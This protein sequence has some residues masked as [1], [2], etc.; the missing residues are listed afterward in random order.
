MH[1]SLGITACLF[2]AF[3]WAIA[4]VF[5]S[6]VPMRAA[7]IAAFKNTFAT[8][9]MFLLLVG[10][11]WPLGRPVFQAGS[12]AW[13]YLGWSGVIGLVLGDVAY[14]R[15]LQILGPRQGLTLTLLTPPLTALLGRYWLSERLTLTTWCAIGVTLAG[16]AVVMRER[17]PSR[18]EQ[19]GTAPASVAWGLLCALV[20]VSAQ[21]VGSIL[22]KIGTAGVGSVE[23]TFIRLLVA[24]LFTLLGA[25]LLRRWPSVRDVLRSRRASVE[26]TLAAF[27]GTFLG[28]WLMLI[29]FKYCEAGV[30]STLL[31]TSPLFIIPIAWYFLG[32]R[33][34]WTAIAGAT[35]AFV[36]AGWLIATLPGVSS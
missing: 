18:G 24:T 1:H 22:L 15:S 5:Y 6:R 29:G 11:T 35:L 16:L 8:C 34:S 27:L 13:W 4:S 7:S 26:L 33:A 19:P 10:S 20:G 23:A 30:A 9:L 17:W 2:A 28:V 31:S 21:A 14:F 25:L 32:D 3:A 12:S 36:G